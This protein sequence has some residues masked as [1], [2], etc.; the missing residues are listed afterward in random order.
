M[1]SRSGTVRRVQSR[2]DRTK[3]RALTGRAT[4]SADR[5]RQRGRRGA[6]SRPRRRARTGVPPAC[7]AARRGRR[8]ARRRL[9]QVEP[10]ERAQEAVRDE[11]VDARLRVRVDPAR[12]RTTRS[13]GRSSRPRPRRAAR[14]QPGPSA[15]RAPHV[16]LQV[17]VAVA[18]GRATSTPSLD[19]PAHDPALVVH[20]VLG[21]LK[22]SSTNGRRS[23][24]T[25]RSPSV[26]S[27]RI[28][29]SVHARE[30]APV[31]AR[32]AL[33]VRR[34]PERRRARPPASS[35]SAA[36]TERTAPL[37]VHRRVR[38]SGSRDRPACATRRSRVAAS[39]FMPARPAT[40]S[41]KPSGCVVDARR[42]RLGATTI[43]ALEAVDERARRA[44]ARP[45]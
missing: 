33:E 39:S 28:S 12:E 23:S 15:R 9:L 3:L 11:H 21:R 40:A 16:D 35:T 8:S 18:A 13:P 7:R 41:S 6:A 25:K 10:R 17:A 32:E 29:P 34:R 37:R 31:R 45:A 22:R 43:S 5:Q 38:R 4:A 26:Y 44:R 27:T 20:L 30:E 36:W 1:R 2:H 42:R 14:A 24:T 19:A